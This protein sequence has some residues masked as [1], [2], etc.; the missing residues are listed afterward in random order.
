MYRT[1]LI[2]I[3]VLSELYARIHVLNARIRE[4]NDL[5]TNLS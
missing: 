2:K 3:H 1:Q 4:S 5:L